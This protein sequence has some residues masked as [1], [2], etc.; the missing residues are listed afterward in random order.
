MSQFLHLRAF[1]GRG[2]LPDVTLSGHAV[3]PMNQAR[4]SEIPTS[5]L[6]ALYRDPHSYDPETAFAEA[7][8]RL[9]GGEVA[10][11]LREDLDSFQH[12]GLGGL[13]DA[14]QSALRA[15]YSKLPGPYAGEVVAWLEGKFVP[16]PEDLAA[17]G[18][19]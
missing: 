19:G 9:C 11:A 4:L 17:F 1:E 8:V 14:E 3:N 5:T 6:S 18:T 15:R 2:D 16:T 10:A 12:V 13:S 7:A